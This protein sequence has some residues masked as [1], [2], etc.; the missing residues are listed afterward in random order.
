LFLIGGFLKIVSSETT[1]PNEP[2]LGK[3]KHLWK[4]FYKDCSFR[5]DS[6]ANM[7]ATG[8]SCFRLVDTIRNKNGLWWPCLLTDWD[9]MSNIYRRPSIDTS[10][11]ISVH[12]AKRFERIFLQIGQSET[13]IACGDHVC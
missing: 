9:E 11:Q 10:Y 7:A 3:K 5:P 1:F 6:L 4:V 12:L 13:R 8:N 2:K